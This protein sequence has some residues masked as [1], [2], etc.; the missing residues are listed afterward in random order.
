[1]ADSIPPVTLSV[2]RWTFATVLVLPLGWQ[3]LK[4]DWPIIRAHWGYYL[5][6]ALVSVTGFNTLI[7]IA[8]HSTQAVNLSLIST[9]GTPLF[10]LIMGRI[11]WCERIFL[12]QLIGMCTAFA[13]VLLLLTHGDMQVI[14]NLRFAKG[15]LWMLAA[16]FL[17]A[18][19]S[20]LMLRRPGPTSQLGVFTITFM[21][22]LLC[23]MPFWALEI[24][25]TPAFAAPSGATFLFQWLPLGLYL[26]GLAS[27]AAFFCWNKAIE[28]LGSAKA[29]VIYFTLPAFCGV[30]ALFILGEPL[31]PA[32]FFSAAFITFGIWLAIR[33]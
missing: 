12:R 20:L 32:H 27:L 30:E 22:G 13:G 16:T 3:H 9:A 29:G 24:S 5:L 26:G 18:S 15:D 23:L 2:L 25:L 1:M 17:F 8:G 14:A 4:E 7:Y 21:V 10:M 31:L 28:Y 33:K 11:L 6:I 19:Y